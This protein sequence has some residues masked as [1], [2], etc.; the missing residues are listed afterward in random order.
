MSDFLKDLQRRR[1]VY[2]LGSDLPISNE[3]VTNLIKAV[4]RESPSAFNSQTQRVVFLFG[5]AHKRLWEITEEALKPLTPPEAFA[6]TQA[7]LQGFANGAGTAL[8][9]E[10]TEVVKNLQEN[11]ALYADKF[12]IWSQQ[13]SGIAQVSSWAALAQENIGA[14]LQHYNP[15]IDEAVAKEW[16]IPANWELVAQLVFGSIEQPAGEKEYRSDEGR[17][18]E[19]N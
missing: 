7:R 16:S 8:F 19:F 2:A 15:V 11:F 18:L 14:N 3:E 10:D 6:G 5:E 12:P 17:F 4:V 9:F 1:T 13:A